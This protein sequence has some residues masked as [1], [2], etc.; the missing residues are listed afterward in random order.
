VRTVKCRRAAGRIDLGASAG[1]YHC[2]HNAYP[3]LNRAG[4]LQIIH[5]QRIRRTS[6]PSFAG[7]FAPFCIRRACRTGDSKLFNLLTTFDGRRQPTRLQSAGHCRT[8]GKLP[9]G[10]A[11]IIPAMR[12]RKKLG[13]SSFIC[14]FGGPTVEQRAT[15]F[16]TLPFGSQNRPP[17][18]RCRAS[19]RAR[20]GPS[21]TVTFSE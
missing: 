14:S 8:A 5:V 19:R 13:A 20:T 1:K 21:N 9:L 3:R 16:Q 6:L 18:Q 2:V 4:C 7:L 11:E 12:P 10:C 15:W 17:A